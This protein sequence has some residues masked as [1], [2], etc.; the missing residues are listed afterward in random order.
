MTLIGNINPT[1][2][3]LRLMNLRLRRC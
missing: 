1:Q 2:I 3:T